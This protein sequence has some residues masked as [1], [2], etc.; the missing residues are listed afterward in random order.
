MFVVR[1]CYA[2]R[3]SSELRCSSIK[4][5]VVR[6]SRA[7]SQARASSFVKRLLADLADVVVVVVVVVRRSLLVVAFIV[8]RYSL[9]VARWP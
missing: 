5:F 3:R 9:L 1:R 8:A 6:Q 4:S 7:S 2:I